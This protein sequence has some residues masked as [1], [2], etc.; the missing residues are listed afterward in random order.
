MFQRGIWQ[1]V[2]RAK[3][4]PYP[5]IQQSYSLELFQG[6]DSKKGGRMKEELKEKV[7]YCR[8]FYISKRPNIT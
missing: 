6:N 5:L 8:T 3:K 2:S 4:C 1:K 7:F